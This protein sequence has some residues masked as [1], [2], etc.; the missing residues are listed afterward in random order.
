MIK[1]LF[2][3]WSQ[4]FNLTDIGRN[5]IIVLIYWKLVQFVWFLVWIA[6]LYSHRKQLVAVKFSKINQHTWK[7]YFYQKGYSRFLNINYVIV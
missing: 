6:A 4:V 3:I 5:Q 1:E 7:I 2:L